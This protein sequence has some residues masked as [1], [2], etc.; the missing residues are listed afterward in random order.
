MANILRG[1]VRTPSIQRDRAGVRDFAHDVDDRRYRLNDDDGDHRVGYVL[2]Q[3][4]CNAI[5][6]LDGREARGGNV[7]DEMLMQYITHQCRESGS[8]FR[9]GEEESA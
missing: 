4:A 1:N 7:A 9:V 2:F 8:D 6:E 5:A 3:R